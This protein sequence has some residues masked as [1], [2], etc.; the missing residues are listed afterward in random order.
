MAAEGVKGTREVSRRALLMLGVSASAG[1][2]LACSKDA[3]A[4]RPRAASGV[5]YSFGAPDGRVIDERAMR[6]RVTVL[7]FATT[8]DIASQEQARR[9][10]VIHRTYEPRLNVL[11]VMLEPPRNIELVRTFRQMLELSYEVVMA[12]PE[13]L[14]GQGPFGDVRAV[15]S[16]VVLDRRG[17]LVAAHAG[18]L[19]D[20]DLRRLVDRGRGAGK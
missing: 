9:L 13:L 4:D 16:W 12:G 19:T 2:A 17:E 15:P 20:R 7:L 1:L 14:G 3:G 6:G 5:T 11:C 10:D 18:P 8:F